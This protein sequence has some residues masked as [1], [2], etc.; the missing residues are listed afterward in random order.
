MKIEKTEIVDDLQIN[1]IPDV[2]E[3]NIP[4]KMANMDFADRME[5]LWNLNEE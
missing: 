5:Y 2:V 1:E 4:D 3:V